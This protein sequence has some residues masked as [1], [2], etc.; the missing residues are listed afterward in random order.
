MAK[1]K[2]KLPEDVRKYVIKLCNRIVELDDNDQATKTA[3]SIKSYTQT[4]KALTVGQINWLRNNARMRRIKVMAALEKLAVE[5]TSGLNDSASASASAS[6]LANGDV[7]NMLFK[8]VRKM[9]K[10]MEAHWSD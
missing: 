8:E 2:I 6:A 7:V 3:K 4:D 5:P 9:R 10:L 1:P